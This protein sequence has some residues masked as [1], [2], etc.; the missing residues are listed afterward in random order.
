MISK[1]KI[2][3]CLNDA[4]DIKHNNEIQRSKVKALTNLAAF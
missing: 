3:S 4:K 1:S 2:K